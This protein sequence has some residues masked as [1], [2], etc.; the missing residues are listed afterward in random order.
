VET[1]IKKVQGKDLDAI[2]LAYA[3]VK[4]LGLDQWISEK[5]PL[6]LILPAVWQ[7]VI[8][9]ETREKDTEI[10]KLLEL[11]N[12]Q[13]TFDEIQAERAFLKVLEGGCQVPIAA[14]AKVDGDRLDC[15]VWWHPW[16]GGNDH[17]G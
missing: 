10:A 8:A 13:K 5:I 14:L 4:R 7:G 1:R 15:E 12:D 3:G 11:V 9:I 2:V 16:M 17:Q 6:E